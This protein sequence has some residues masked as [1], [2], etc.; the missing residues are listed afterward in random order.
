ML[1]AHYYFTCQQ[2]R[3]HGA[4]ARSLITDPEPRQA[5]IPGGESPLNARSLLLVER[6][7]RAAILLPA[8]LSHLIAESFLFPIA[9][10]L[11]AGRS[12]SKL[13][14]L[15]ADSVGPARSE[16]QVAV[17]GATFVAMTGDYHF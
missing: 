3:S 17:C 1:T 2:L 14:K 11:D 4:A 12:N 9:D 5:A 13:Y 15:V 7:V 6:E 8:L 16:R 10:R